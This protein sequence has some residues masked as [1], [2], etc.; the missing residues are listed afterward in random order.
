MSINNIPKIS[1]KD[2][3][4]IIS[5]YQNAKIRDRSIKEYWLQISGPC[6]RKTL[7][8]VIL[9]KNIF[10]PLIYKKKFFIFFCII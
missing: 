8:N 2:R 3:Y 9:K 7:K 4:D 10:P 6:K 1:S 5:W